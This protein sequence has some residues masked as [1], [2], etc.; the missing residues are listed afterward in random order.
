MPMTCMV[1]RH[2]E[3]EAIDRALVEGAEIRS[4]A[5]THGLSEHAV[6]RH[7]EAHVPLALQR[8]HEAREGVRG[9]DLHDR[10]A[11]HL[12]DCASA[13]QAATKAKDR[14]ALNGALG[15]RRAALALAFR[16]TGEL[17]DGKPT[18]AVQVNVG[19][20]KGLTR[21]MVLAVRSQLLGIDASEAQETTTPQRPE[22]LEATAVDDEG[23]D[24]DEDLPRTH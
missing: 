24:D 13:V 3:R 9:L 11:R 7:R 10:L 8:A 21:E 14:A 4:L 22:M 2:P 6:W 18:T 5:R 19:E 16:L 23:V 12:D 20:F 1:C 15:Q 17:G